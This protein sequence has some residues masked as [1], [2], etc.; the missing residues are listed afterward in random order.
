MTILLLLQVAPEGW[1]VELLARPNHPTAVAAGP[2]GRVYVAEDPM[3]MEGP[4]D[5]KL[6]RV[7]CVHPDGRTTVFA[8]RLGPV[9]GL[10]WHADRLYVH[11]C[12]RVA[13]WR[14]DAGV[15]RDPVGILPATHPDPSSGN[16]YN[17]H[18]PA[19][20]RLHPDGWFYMAIGDKGIPGIP[21]PDGSL[22]RMRGGGVIRFKPD[23]SAIELV[24][25]GTRNLLDVAITPAGDVF[26]FDN[27]DNAAWGARVLHVVPGADFGYPWDRGKPWVRPAI[28]EA[29]GIPA[30]CAAFGD[31]V[32][33][34]DWGRSRIVRYR[35]EPV[36]DTFRIAARESLITAGQEEFRPVGI[37]VSGRHVLIADWNTAARRTA[38][39]AGRLFRFTA[40]HPPVVSSSRPKV[41]QTRE[42]RPTPLLLDAPWDGS[43]WG[44]R[45]ALRP[46]PLATVEH[47]GTPRLRAELQRR[48]VDP[49]PAVRRSAIEDLTPD[50]AS[51]DLLLERLNVECDPAARRGLFAALVRQED[52]RVS[53]LA[54]EGVERFDPDLFDDALA[55][56]RDPGP[57]RRALASAPTSSHLVRL[58]AVVPSRDHLKHADPSVRAAAVRS[59]DDR[60]AVPELLALGDEGLPALLRIPDP[61][62]ETLYRKALLGDAET[63]LAARR[64]LSALGLDAGPKAAPPSDP[65]GGDADRG[66]QLYFGGLACSRCHAVGREG[67][68]LGPELTMIGAVYSR[69]ILADQILEPD[70]II[71]GAYRTT[72]LRLRSGD[73]LSGL[74]RRESDAELDL[75]DAD[76]RITRVL[77]RDVAERRTSETSIMPSGLVDGLP[78]S[79]F[80]DLLSFLQSL[81]GEESP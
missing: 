29:R 77:R 50:R 80:A 6:G 39:P 73:V 9:F 36:G 12:H 37:A 75:S 7:L 78:D 41:L 46:R 24:A 30:G 56:L 62:A 33:L 10:A 26:A 58:L 32:L 27:D 71:H 45:P 20:F 67:G 35:F 51:A 60:E 68:D 55:A 63:R 4:V 22:F 2:S 13:A 52:P 57:A 11:D 70:R 44:S 66:R 1:Q 8:D 54:A 34:C 31:D 25:T 38:V 81:K 47:A 59:T 5:A 64:A 15:G 19:G 16:R 23:G 14:D 3:D 74:L 69:R 48:L 17:T 53:R 79:D 18:I 21:R 43:W 40:P 76:G 72:K 28:H 61:R 65:G 42:G 49:D